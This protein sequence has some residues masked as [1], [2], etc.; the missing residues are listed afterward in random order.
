MKVRELI[1]HLAKFDYESLIELDNANYLENGG[2]EYYDIEEIY[3][4]ERNYDDA[5]VFR[6]KKGDRVI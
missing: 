6:L 1:E 2:D 4:E 5:V 3:L